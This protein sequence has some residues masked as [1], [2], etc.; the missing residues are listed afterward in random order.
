MRTLTPRRP[1]LRAVFAALGAAVFVALAEAGS[2][3][4]EPCGSTLDLP[5]SLG[6]ADLVVVAKRPA[7]PKQP[8][9]PAGGPACDELLVEGVLKGEFEGEKLRVRS[10]Y[11]MCPYGIILSEGTYVVIL[12]KASVSDYESH[13]ADPEGG[14]KAA[15]AKKEG[16]YVPVGHGC[17]VKA[18]AVASGLVEA[19]G[20]K[21]TLEEFRDKYGL[22][23]ARV[24]AA[25]GRPF[26]AWPGGHFGAGLFGPAAASLR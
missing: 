12:G 26:A 1:A 10:W 5:R 3:A 8:E 25:P 17:A 16:L 21:L 6:K 22:R 19:E 23:G 18:L 7:V 20:V 24:A 4:C 14:C 2:L 11:G 13:A 9:N 15:L